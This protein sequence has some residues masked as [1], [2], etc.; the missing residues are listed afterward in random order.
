MAKL[1]LSIGE[2]EVADVYTRKIQREYNNALFDGINA[3]KNGEIEQFPV[4]NMQNA[5][6]SL[7]LSILGKGE[8]YVSTL[9]TDDFDTVL[10]YAQKL[11]EKKT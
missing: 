1:T 2:V 6:D 10:E 9:S 7:V 4:M 3:D 5:A 8:E 11:Q